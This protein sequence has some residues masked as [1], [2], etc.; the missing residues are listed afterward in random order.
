M[1]KV[2][3][4]YTICF[5][6]SRYKVPKKMASSRTKIVIIL[7]VGVVITIFGVLTG[8]FWPS[9]YNWTITKVSWL[10]K[11]KSIESLFIKTIKIVYIIVYIFTQVLVLTPTSVSYNMWQE[12]P[13]PMYLKFYMFNWTNP[14]EFIASNAKPNFVEM[15]PYVF[16]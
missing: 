11:Y 14:R 10:E 3:T 7:I 13:I 16:R 15:G 9:I 5:I 4:N 1:K 8:S 2:N 12:T 6:V